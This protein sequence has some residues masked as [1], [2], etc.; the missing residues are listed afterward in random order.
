MSWLKCFFMKEKV[1]DTF[2]GHVT[3]VTS[4]GLFVT[5]DSLFVEG[6]V[7]VSEL[8]SEYFQYNDGLHE[9]RGES[10]GIRYRLT[11]AIHVQISRVDLDA[12]RIE[13][14]L[15]QGMKFEQFVRDSAPKAHGRPGKGGR[16]SNPDALAQDVTAAGLTAPVLP[17][18]ERGGAGRTRGGNKKQAANESRTKSA[19][20]KQRRDEIQK[21]KRV[22]RAK[23]AAASKMRSG[24]KK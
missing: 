24:R 8:G 3:G 7:H 11:D 5:L 15:V 19:A 1:G 21:A 2:Q 9:L 17:P 14:R 22:A 6:L 10:S 13:F 16:R 20:E 4:F 12:R 18:A 23:P